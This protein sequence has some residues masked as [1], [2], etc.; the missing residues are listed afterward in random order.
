VLNE[1]ETKLLMQLVISLLLLAAGMWV[2]LQGGYSN[3]VQKFATG[4]IG[5]VA[6]FWLK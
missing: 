6:G 2:L 4:W 5:L 3:E 1:A